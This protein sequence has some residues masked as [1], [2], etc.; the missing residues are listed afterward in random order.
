[1][2]ADNPLY[3]LLYDLETRLLQ[4][5]I[6]H[7]PG[8]LERLLAEDFREFGAGGRVYDRKAIID[9]LAVES[10]TSITIIDFLLTPLAQDVALVTYRAVICDRDGQPGNYSLRSSVWK[11]TG[12]V[13]QMIFHQGTPTGRP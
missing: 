12:D 7:S 9:A 10:E 11:R 5:D 3:Q 13:W 6:R 1:M 8:E 4:P 2:A